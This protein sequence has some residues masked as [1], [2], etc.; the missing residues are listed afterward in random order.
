MISTPVVPLRVSVIFLFSPLSLSFS[1]SVSLTLSLSLLPCLSLSHPSLS[2]SLSLAPSLPLSLSLSLFHSLTLTLNLPCICSGDRK[3][4]TS[5]GTELDDN[6]YCK[7][8]RTAR[9]SITLYKH[10][11][12]NQ[13]ENRSAILRAK[14]ILARTLQ[15]RM[16]P[17]RRQ[18]SVI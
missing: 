18:R 7:R 3:V 2:P 12:Q 4:V 17:I 16:N 13:V 11:G 9:K 5:R 15:K 14:R 10:R 8:P 1:L 6:C